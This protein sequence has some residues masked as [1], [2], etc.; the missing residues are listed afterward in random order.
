MFTDRFTTHYKNTI[1]LAYQTALEESRQVEVPD[2]LIALLKQTGSLGAELLKK[3]KLTEDNIKKFQNI[4]TTLNKKNKDVFS[5]QVLQIIEKSVL[6][7]YKMQHTYVGTEHLLSSLLDFEKQIT[8]YLQNTKSLEPLKLQVETILKSASRFP[9]ITKTFDNQDSPSALSGTNETKK[10][11]EDDEP[12]VSELQLSSFVTDLTDIDNQETIDPVIGREAELERMINILGRRT[13]NNPLLLGDPG[14]GKTAIVEGL[15]KKIIEHN[16]PDFL[17]N[18]KILN[19]DLTSLVSGTIYRGEFE[20]RLKQIIDEVKQNPNIILFID[21]LH[22]LVGAGAT[23]GSMDAS[24][25]LKPAL[26]RGQIRCIG[27]TTFDEY[28]KHIERDSALERRFQCIS[29]NEPS[30][31]ET[32]QILLGIKKNYEK[33]HNVIISNDIIYKIVELCEKYLPQYKMPDKAID[34]LD[35]SCAKCAIQKSNTGMMKKIKE[36]KD[37]VLSFNQ[38][39][40]ENLILEKF[41]KAVE[42]QKL[43]FNEIKKLKKL[44]E[45]YK[46]KKKTLKQKLELDDILKTLSTRTQIPLDNFDFHSSLTK[47]NTNKTEQETQQIFNIEKQINEYII[48]QKEVVSKICN[49]IKKS[50]AGITDSKKPIGSFVFLG[51]NGVGKTELAKVLAKT[52]FGSTKK[53]ISLNMSEFSEGFALSKLI[54]SPAGYVGYMDETLLT[55]KI[56]KNPHCVILFDEI[57][58]AHTSIFNIISQ[59]IDEGFITDSIGKQID[60]SHTLIIMTSNLGADTFKNNSGLGFAEKINTN[61]LANKQAD[62]KLSINSINSYLLDLLQKTITKEIISRVD[63]VLV[64]NSLNFNNL[65]KIAKMQLTELVTRAKKR[66]IEINLDNN[67]IDFIAKTGFKQ[68]NGARSIK[69]VISELIENQLAEKVLQKNLHN[70]KFITQGNKI[71][72]WRIKISMQK[73]KIVF[74]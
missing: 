4:N 11:N 54:G 64:F 6:T 55:D 47:G 38:E 41:E 72:Q 66:Y 13:K 48:G 2:I 7:A 69:Q 56:K 71:R 59:I 53:L 46:N 52:V 44:E 23:S 34:I 8:E 29:I 21:E 30:Q 28:K 61:I 73:N 58:K 57:E 63:G 18:K 62:Q 1:L 36:F 67:V 20:N 74:L 60:C 42:L 39:I 43:Q 45:N 17:I 9:E 25:I 49:H 40:H 68:K 24:N 31:T 32:I 50:K 37:S 14:V 5:E 27:A 16:V 26:A 10:I 12:D 3:S 19:L 15:A 22:N 51:P 35:E 33:Y 65:K 70:K